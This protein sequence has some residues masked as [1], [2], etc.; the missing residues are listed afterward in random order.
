MKKVLLISLVLVLG[1]VGNVWAV[2]Y[3]FSDRDF[4]SGASWGTMTLTAYDANTLMI[5]YVA[6]SNAVIPSDSEVTGFGFTFVPETTIPSAVQNPFDADF[7]GDRNDLDWIAATNVN[8]I[9]NPANG[10]EFSPQVTKADFFFAVSEGNSN[11]FSPPGIKPGEFD[12]YYL[13]F[14]DINDLTAYLDLS[15]FIEVT[16][17]RLQSLPND[18]NTGSLFLVGKQENGGGQEVPEPSTLL[19]IGTGLLGFGLYGRGKFRK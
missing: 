4:L 1:L 18:I 14:I 12:I 5:K 6:A 7:A 15:D 3:T 10:D 8:M 19:L 2:S 13:D 9:P 16:G 17:I 11:N